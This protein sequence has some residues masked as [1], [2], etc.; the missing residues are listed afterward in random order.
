MDEK[1]F[2]ILFK[3]TEAEW[4]LILLRLGRYAIRVSRSL[5]WRTGSSEEIAGG[6]TAASIVSEALKRVYSGERKWNPDTDP[7]IEK[8]LMDVID[9]LLNHLAESADNTM[10]ETLPEAD[11]GEGSPP[12]IQPGKAEI[13]AEWLSRRCPTPE[14][15][16]LAQE[17][18]ARNDQVISGL[19]EDCADD[20]IL[21]KVLEGIVDGCPNSRSIAEKTGLSRTEV[22][23]ATKRL[24]TK[25]VLLRKQ[26]AQG[27]NLPATRGKQDV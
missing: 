3:M 24:D 13:G 20:P 18:A 10:F 26:L 21:R 11:P 27:A 1:A 8:Y 2:L 12:D 23:A 4:D 16:M 15:E 25:I 19:I 6:E 7:S 9:S 22:Y 5:Y 17:R 14:E